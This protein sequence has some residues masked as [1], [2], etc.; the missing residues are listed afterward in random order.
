MPLARIG[1]GIVVVICFLGVALL[2][3]AGYQGY[4]GLSGAVGIAAA[5]N[6]A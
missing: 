2:L 5:I 3:L 6:L 4:A 1:W